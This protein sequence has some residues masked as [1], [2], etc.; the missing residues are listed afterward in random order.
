MANLVGP[1]VVARNVQSGLCAGRESRGDSI[2]ARHASCTETE[3][4]G[5]TSAVTARPTGSRPGSLDHTESIDAPTGSRPGSLDHTESI[6]A[7]AAP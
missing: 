3:S 7:P 2:A 5:T 6:D 1:R 4:P